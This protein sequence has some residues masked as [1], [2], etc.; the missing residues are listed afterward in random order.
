MA[1][2]LAATY[3]VENP[4]GYRQEE[5][6]WLAALDLDKHFSFGK[7]MF[8][9]FLLPVGLVLIYNTVLLVLTSLT[10]CR[11]DRQL[12]STRSSSLTKRFLVSFSLAVLLG[13]SWTLGYF[14]LVTKETPHLIFSILFCLC[15]ATQVVF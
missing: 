7:P 9:A 15:S 2:T 11:V 8:W 3:R 5:F 10:T 14:V 13:L 4:L 1:I 12:T 6:C